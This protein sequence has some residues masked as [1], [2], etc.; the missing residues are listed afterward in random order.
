MSNP[1]ADALARAARHAPQYQIAA[2]YRQTKD[3]N[4]RPM[5]RQFELVEGGWA[6]LTWHDADKF[7]RQDGGEVG[8]GKVVVVDVADPDYDLIVLLDGTYLSVASA[9][10]VDAMRAS[11]TFEVRKWTGDP[12]LL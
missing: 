10:K 6:V 7:D 11:F 3:Q 1:I 2:C 12:P 9:G 8:E 4:G 5:A